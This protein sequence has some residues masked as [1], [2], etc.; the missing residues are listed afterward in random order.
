MARRRGQHRRAARTS[1]TTH[2]GASARVLS[3]CSPPFGT[4]GSTSRAAAE[5]V[6]QGW[7]RTTAG[8]PRFRRRLQARL[9]EDGGPD[10]LRA[11]HGELTEMLR[12]GTDMTARRAPLAACLALAAELAAE[13]GIVPFRRPTSPPGPRYSQPTRSAT[14][15]PRW[16]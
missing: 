13:W 5:A 11:R 3:I 9:T 8:R 10:K 14:T 6:R 7:K 16:R 4:D 1:F 12:G 15:A 2:Q